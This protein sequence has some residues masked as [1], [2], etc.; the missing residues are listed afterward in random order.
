M[1]LTS[2]WRL[3]TGDRLPDGSYLARIRGVQVR[4]IEADV[5]ATGTDGTAARD[6]YRLVTT[7]LDPVADPAEILVRLYHERWEIESAYYALRHTLMRG[8]VL[9]SAD[10]AGVQQE[11]WALLTLYQLLRTAMVDAV[12]TALGTN[13]DRASF[14]VALEAARDQLVAAGV[15]EDAGDQVVGRIGR[16]VL[17]NL[18]PARRARFSARRVKCPLSRYTY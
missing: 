1:R 10:P 2:L 11:M 14:T 6:G 5:T 16:A 15:P 18:L 7:L 9:R 4:I 3:P 13:P 12:E 17:A 8:R